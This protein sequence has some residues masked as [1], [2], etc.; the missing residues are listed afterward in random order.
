M[1]AE[2]AV[3]IVDEILA[4]ISYEH[5]VID[6][7]DIPYDLCHPFLMRIRSNSRDVNLARTQMDK[8]KNVVVL[9]RTL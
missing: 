6:I 3:P 4:V 1:F 8:E 2:L 7:G 5:A 9:Q